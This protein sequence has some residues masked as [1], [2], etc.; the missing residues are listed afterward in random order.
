M[1]INN[2]DAA[3]SFSFFVCPNDDCKKRIKIYSRSFAG[4]GK[5]C[6]FCKCFIPNVIWDK[7]KKYYIP[8]K[9]KL[10]RS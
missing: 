8:N 1:G 5:R 3:G 4:Q 10:H 6:P 7:K 2:N 9:L